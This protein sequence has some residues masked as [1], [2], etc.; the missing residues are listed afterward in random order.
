MARKRRRPKPRCTDW[1]LSPH[2]EQRA[3]QMGVGLEH[4]FAVL[5]DPAVTYPPSRA[6]LARYPNRRLAAS[7]DLTVVY[8]SSTRVIVTVLWNSDEEFERG[9]DRPRTRHRRR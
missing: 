8:D 2:A 3:D 6:Y 4:V 5:R 9:G 7:G 1:V